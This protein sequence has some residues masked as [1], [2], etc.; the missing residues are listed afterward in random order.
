MRKRG[1]MAKTAERRRGA[2]MTSDSNNKLRARILAAE[3]DPGHQLCP[4]CAGEYIVPGTAAGDR[5]GVCPK[6]YERGMRNAEYATQG[7]LIAKNERDALRKG[8]QRLR[9]GLGVSADKPLKP[10]TPL[11]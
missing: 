11:F 10:R 2:T 1:S 3:L 4:I 7:A 8:T 5:F 6:C 9:R